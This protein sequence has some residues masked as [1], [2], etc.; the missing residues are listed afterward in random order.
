MKLALLLLNDLGFFLKLYIE[1]VTL[2][3]PA[4][5][6]MLFIL[7]NVIAFQTIQTSIDVEFKGATLGEDIII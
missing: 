6:V 4:S 5:M 3:T 2:Y 1:E 7:N